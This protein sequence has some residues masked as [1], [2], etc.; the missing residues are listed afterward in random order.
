MSHAAVA[1]IDT[2]RPGIPISRLVKVELRKMF[3][4]RS[5]LWLMIVTGLLIVLAMA[6]TLLVLGLND[7]VTITASGFSQVMTIP[8][9]ILLPIFAILT[10]T[11]EWGQR[12]HLVSF[13]LEPRRY[14]VVVAKLVAVTL[15]AMGTLVLAIAAGAVG[16]VLYGAITG[17]DVVWNVE[18]RELVWTIVV[19]LAF[20][21]M[22]FALSA[23]LLNTP[24][25]IAVFYV[26]AL[27]LP[28]IVYPILLGLFGWARDVLPWL[29]F[30]YAAAPLISGE[31]IMGERV[32]VGLVEY[33]RFLFTV[34]IWVFL[35]GIFGA[36][37]VLKAEVK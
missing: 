11:G 5:G 12:T 6:I 14:R 15:L 2:A 17:N 20:F 9:S 8:V 33:L 4:T 28:L 23:V 18:G 10:V 13:T 37:R 25:A 24:A 1:T 30:N 19:Q 35:P 7:G 34:G 31:T 36:M 22:A 16:N 32:N 27:I 26:V 21:L 29:D 3:D